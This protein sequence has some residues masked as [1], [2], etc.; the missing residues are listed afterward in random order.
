MNPP[1][2]QILAFVVLVITILLSSLWVALDAKRRGRSGLVVVFLCLLTW[3]LGYLFWRAVRPPA[4]I[5]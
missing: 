2:I 3:P 4:P 1:P 5:R